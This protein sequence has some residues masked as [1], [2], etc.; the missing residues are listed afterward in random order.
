[1]FSVFQRKAGE[2]VG[3]GEE[4]LHGFDGVSQGFPIVPTV[5]MVFGLDNQ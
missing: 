2:T 1:M 5:Q 3:A 4:S